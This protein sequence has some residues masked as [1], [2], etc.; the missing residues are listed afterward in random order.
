M[1][2][3]VCQQFVDLLLRASMLRGSFTD[4]DTLCI[5]T[6]EVEQFRTGQAVVDDHVGQH[7]HFRPRAGEEARVAGAGPTRVA[8][9]GEMWVD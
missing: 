8:V 2:G 4:V 6:R 9:P 1:K 3:I 5:G 7:Q